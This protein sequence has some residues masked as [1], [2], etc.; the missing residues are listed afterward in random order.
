[1]RIG[2]H[3]SIAGHIYQSIE[4]ARVLGCNTMQIFSRDP[5]QWRKGRLNL[6][7]IEEFKKSRSRCDIAPVFAHIPY[8]SNLDS[9]LP[10]LYKNSIKAYIED[11]KEAEALGIEYLVTHMGSHKKTGEE[12]GIKR[13]TSAINNILERTKKS[14]VHILLEN[15][16]GAGSWLGYKFE[17]QRRIID[18][19]EQ[20]H[21]VGIC[22][23]TCHSYSA[24]Y[25]LADKEGYEETIRQIDEIVGLKRLKLIHLNDSKDKIGSHRDRHEHIGKG[26]IG[27][28][29]FRLILNDARLKDTAFILETPKDTEDSDRINLETV[30][31][32]RRVGKG[33]I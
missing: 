4:R 22:L 18:G 7:E 14:P 28:E 24:G 33:I 8:L 13:F 6:Q 26:K 16:S 9:P 5:R 12:K 31:K 19:I 1:M 27:Y 23:D 11:M 29:A 2:V 25:D 32:L 20:K 3:V 30:R 15:T 10:V 21:R 17:H